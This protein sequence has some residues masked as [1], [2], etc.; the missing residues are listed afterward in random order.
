MTAPDAQG[1]SPRNAAENLR[2]RLQ[3]DLANLESNSLRRELRALPSAG[4]RVLWRGKTMLNLA[5]NDYL[6][7][8]DHPHLKAAAKQAIEQHGV[9]SGASRLVA[10]HLDIHEQTEASFAAFKH[11]EAALIFPTGYTANLAVLTALPQPGDLICQDKLNHA[12]LI[13]AAKYSAAEVRTY[14]HSHGPPDHRKLARLL[15]R[16]LAESPEATRWIV[17]DSVF[18]MDGDTADLP[19]LCELAQRYDALVVIDEAHGTGVLGETGSGLAEQL[20]VSEHI[21]ITISTASKAMGSLGGIVTGDRAVIETLINRA[22]PLIY[23][24]A[25]PPAQAASIG[26]AMQVIADEPDLRLRLHELSQALRDRLS[27][28]GWPS[29][30]QAIPT[31]IVPLMT[32]EI[33]AALALQQRLEQHGVLA[34]AIRPPTVAPGQT[35]VRLSLRADLTDEDLAAVVAAVGPS[36][37]Y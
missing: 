2:R 28:L 15:E 4:K 14:P 9:G 5:G 32:G 20:G 1:V 16:H 17:T 3:A 36:M 19:G 27:E 12:S 25:V 34:V 29:L 11:A 33:D 31:P 18:S 23:S 8:A 7:L 10:G 37:H 26:A 6:A 13:D 35:R 24:T 21:L 22:R 30:Q